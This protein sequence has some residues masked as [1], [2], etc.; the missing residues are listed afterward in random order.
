[1]LRRFFAENEGFTAT[2]YAVVAFLVSILI[3][4]GAK[5]IGTKLSVN[6]FGAVAANL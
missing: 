1:M 4:A 3:V 2:E 5:A 6:Y